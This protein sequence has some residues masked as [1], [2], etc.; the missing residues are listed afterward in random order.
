MAGVLVIDLILYL[1]LFSPQQTAS[2]NEKN[3]LLFLILNSYSFN[4]KRFPM[5]LT[6]IIASLFFFLGTPAIICGFIYLIKKSKNGVEI[7]KLKRDI[8]EL[9][10]ENN[11]Y[12]ILLLE[13]EN[14]K[15]DRLIGE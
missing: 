3:M 15:Y 9:E 6:Q 12:K 8:L 4:L 2:S 1:R 11:K 5:D 7:M 14:K 10:A 13:E